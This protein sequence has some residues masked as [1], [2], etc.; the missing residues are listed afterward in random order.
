M[1]C[2]RIHRERMKRPDGRPSGRIERM[3][4]WFNPLHPL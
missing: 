2:Q 1:S 4:D 3:R